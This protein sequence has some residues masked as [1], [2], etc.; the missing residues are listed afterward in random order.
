M[1]TWTT[2]TNQRAS[3]A[4]LT[5]TGEA[6]VI[7][8]DTANYV[9]LTEVPLLVSPTSTVSVLQGVTTYTE[10]GGAP[11]ASQYQVIYAGRLMG[12]ILFNAADNGKSVTIGYKGRGSNVFAR[13]INN[14]QTLK[15]DTDAP[16]S[17]NTAST[18]VKRDGSGGF[19]AGTIVVDLQ[20]YGEIRTAPTI[21]TNVLTLNLLNGNVFTVALNANITTLTISNPRPSGTACSFTLAFTADGTARTVTWPAAVKWPG[22]TAPTLTSTNAKVDTFVFTTWDAGTNWY[23]FTAGQNS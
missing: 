6:H 1:A 13:D 5:I 22:G 8:E 21:S 12:A 20:A 11:A 4:E 16:V 17:T 15:L 3:G 10:V 14:L 2:K 18:V 23:A 9:F 19:S 7:G